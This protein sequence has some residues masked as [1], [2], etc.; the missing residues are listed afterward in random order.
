MQIVFRK[1]HGLQA[2]AEK[3]KILT[4]LTAKR[5]HKI[6]GHFGQKSILWLCKYWKRLDQCLRIKSTYHPSWQTLWDFCRQFRI[7]CRRL[8]MPKGVT[9]VQ[10]ILFLFFSC[11]LTETQTNWATIE[12]EA[13]AVLVAVRKFKHCFFWIKINHSQWSQSHHLPN[14]IRSKI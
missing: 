13:Y 2:F 14:C 12:R 1:F 7:C 8:A 4:D 10:S 5:V 6:A 9:L 3:A 11:K